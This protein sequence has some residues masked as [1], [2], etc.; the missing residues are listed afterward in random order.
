MQR[1]DKK[2][3]EVA[4][5]EI[6]AEFSHKPTS[7]ISIVPYTMTPY[8]GYMTFLDK[9][10]EEYSRDQIVRI[11]PEAETD[12]TIEQILTPNRV[13]ALALIHVKKILGV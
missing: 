8:D 2:A 12:A 7:H 9:V 5:S 1:S 3:L 13:C 6:L 4:A 10:K 11:D